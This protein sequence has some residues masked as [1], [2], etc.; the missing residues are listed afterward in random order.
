M[1]EPTNGQDVCAHSCTQLL[2]ATHFETNKTYSYNVDLTLHIDTDNGVETY[3]LRS[4]RA[5]IAEITAIADVSAYDACKLVLQLRSVHI[6]GVSNHAPLT[7]QL[8]SEPLHF[9]Y[10]DDKVLHLCESSDKQWVIN[11]KKSIIISLQMSNFDH[12]QKQSVGKDKPIKN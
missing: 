7:Q 5:Q 9:A 12:S 2:E 6:T 8:E 4:G 10:D 11:V 3:G 1:S